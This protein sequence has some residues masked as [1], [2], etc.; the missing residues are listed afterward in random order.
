MI[1][2]VARLLWLLGGYEYASRVQSAEKP[3]QHEI[4]FPFFSVTT[5]GLAAETISEVGCKARCSCLKLPDSTLKREQNLRYRQDDGLTT[6]ATSFTR[7]SY[8]IA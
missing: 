5:P 7:N 2:R 8:A 3:E 1:L 4:R 6:V